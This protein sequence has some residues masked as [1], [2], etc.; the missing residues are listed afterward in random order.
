MIT[1]SDKIKMLR[2]HR[3]GRNR[4]IKN[5]VRHGKNVF[6]RECWSAMQKAK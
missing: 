6:C 2:C 4:R 3:C 1:E 5:L